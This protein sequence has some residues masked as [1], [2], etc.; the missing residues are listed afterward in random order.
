MHTRGELIRKCRVHQPAPG[1]EKGYETSRELA[2]RHKFINR[3]RSLRAVDTAVT[4]PQDPQ[5]P[6]PGGLP[7]TLHA[8]HRTPGLGYKYCAP[9]L[10][11][12]WSDIPHPPLQVD[13]NGTRCTRPVT[14]G[15]YSG[16][17]MQ[18]NSCTAPPSA[19][20][21]TY[22]CRWITG[23]FAKASDTTTTLKCVSLFFGT[24]G[25]GE[26]CMVSSEPFPPCDLLS[27][28]NV[29]HDARGHHASALHEYLG[30][31]RANLV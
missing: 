6:R 19:E 22:L 2:I 12:L 25:I 15:D 26:A 8:L 21:C 3:N 28:V 20:V 14:Q 24:V 4:D 5:K 13:P 10:A 29:L 31:H 30:G 27:N 18:C 17:I 23:L 1:L 16:V 7:Q 11:L 9:A